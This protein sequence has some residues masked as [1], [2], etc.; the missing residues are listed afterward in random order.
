MGTTNETIKN[1]IM[2]LGSA[3]ADHNHQ[4]SNELRN[5]FEKITSCL[6]SDQKLSCHTE[7]D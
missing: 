4:W 2:E 7:I 5:E 3:L 1:L 6:S